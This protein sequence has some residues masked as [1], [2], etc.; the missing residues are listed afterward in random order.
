[1]NSQ[2][3]K[4]SRFNI[5]TRTEDKTL[6]VYNSFS[7]AFMQF[8]GIEADHI[9]NVLDGKA[10]VESDD[11]LLTLTE[12][13][14]LVPHTCDELER[15][16]KLHETLFRQKDRFRLILIPTENCNFNCLYCYE[17]H[18]PQ[19]MSR[20]IIESVIQLVQREAPKLKSMEVMWFGGEPLLAF[21]IVE[22]ISQRILD[23]CRENQIRYRCGMV[24]NGYLL[25]SQ[26]ADRCFS[27][28]VSWF[29]IT[30]D[31][32]PETH[33]KL[34]VL[35]SGEGTF[36]TILSNLQELRSKEYDF[37][38]KIRVNFTPDTVSS[39]PP[40]LKLIKAEFGDDPRYAV[41]F[42]PVGHWGGKH[43]KLIKVCDRITEF[44]YERKLA[45]LAHQEG[46]C[47]DHWR[48]S[49]KIFGKVCYAADPRSF[50]IGTDGT[51]FKCTIAFDDPRN[52][53]G[54]IMPDGS[55]DI[56]EDMHHLWTRSGEEIDTECQMCTFRPVCQGDLCPYLWIRGNERRCPK[57][58]AHLKECLPLLA[59]NAAVVV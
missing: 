19:T 38:V 24:T 2:D 25:T 3:W 12:Q 42:H 20:D 17:E 59:A 44:N 29:Q 50:V 9:A 52:R 55:L 36:D 48:E 15:A 32:P 18:K 5:W 58:K 10:V 6:L 33:N 37:R 51:V 1:M 53:I 16:Q 8:E 35:A 31:G 4:P 41:Y 21:N 22:E 40:F 39:I 27:A 26:R 57:I 28:E 30:L 11:T 13:G 14:F 46:F 23:I 34:R 54:K 47:L 56:D 7:N 43:D 49:L 45:S